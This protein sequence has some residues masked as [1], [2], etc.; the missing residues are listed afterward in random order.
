ML[1]F[2]FSVLGDDGSEYMCLRE[3]G[4]LD[5]LFEV[6]MMIMVFT[7]TFKSSVGLFVST[8]FEESNAVR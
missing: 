6:E 8:T 2:F 4:K 5:I 3:P 1:D 7:S